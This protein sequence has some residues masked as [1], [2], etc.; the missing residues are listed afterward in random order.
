MEKVLLFIRQPTLSAGLEAL[1]KIECKDAKVVVVKELTEATDQLGHIDFDLF[2]LDHD[3]EVKP[4][5]SVMA[6]KYPGLTIMVLVEHYQPAHMLKIYRDGASGV[7]H[8]LADIDEMAFALKTVL[9]GQVYMSDEMLRH[10]IHLQHPPKIS[11]APKLTKRENEI[12]N[13]ILSGKRLS[14]I[15]KVLHVNAKNVSDS[16]KMIYKK[17]GINNLIQLEQYIHMLRKKK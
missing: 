1:I 8:S 11:A 2:I 16:R 14:E 7:I 12:V 6:E 13:M 9:S 17:L 10:L 3:E 4:E 5:V 15:G